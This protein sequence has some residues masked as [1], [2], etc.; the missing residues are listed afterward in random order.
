[1]VDQLS[2]FAAEVT[3][4]AR[5]V[6]TEGRLGG[7]AQ[8]EG[9]SGVWRDLTENVNTLA[10]N[11]TRPGAQHRRGHD[12]RRDRRP[13]QEDHRGRPRR[14]ARAEG[15]DQHDGRPA[16]DL[17]GRGHARRPRGRHRGPPGR[18]G[19]G[20]GRQ[21]RL[22]RPDR[23]RQ[24]D[25]RVADAQPPRDRRRLDR[26]HPGRPHALGDDRGAGRGLG[27]ARQHQPDDRDAPRDDPA[28]RGAGLAELEPR[29]LRR[30]PSGPARAEDRLAPD[31]ERADAARLGAP[32][33]LLH[34]AERR[35]G[36]R[37]PAARELRLQGAQE[38]LEP[39][40]ARRGP[41]RT[42]RDGEA[43]DPDRG[44]TARTTSASR[45]RSARRSRATSS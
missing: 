32:R 5:E 35:R 20:R 45:R 12:R 44:S 24:R 1:M 18:A 39:L 14:G 16:L 23:E 27:P 41:R 42:G 6:G 33:R 37:A 11:L 43:V 17:R 28:Q 30:D 29:P 19:E 25:G 36:R 3:R 40:Q 38:G 13:E 8:V 10:G 15:D 4:V 9:V 2:A 31:H 26:G 21:R 22:A 7:Q 34:G